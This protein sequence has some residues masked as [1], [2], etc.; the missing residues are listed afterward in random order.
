M[1]RPTHLR[2][3]SGLE[4]L[5]AN[6]NKLELSMEP[7]LAVALVAQLQLAAMHP[8]NKGSTA[9]GGRQVIDK[10]IELIEPLSPDLAFCLK[11]GD[12]R[13]FDVKRFVPDPRAN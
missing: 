8:A 10:I 7:E 6:C 12:D 2:L 13:R 3:M 5:K 4:T 9:A 11:C 1:E